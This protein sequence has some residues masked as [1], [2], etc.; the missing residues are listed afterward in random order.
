[1]EPY[2]DDDIGEAALRAVMCRLRQSA[3]LLPD[4]G[5]LMNAGSA[6]SLGTGVVTVRAESVARHVHEALRDSLLAQPPA[7]T[8]G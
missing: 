8:E 7:A 3:A 6:T 5:L 2:D 4:A 1:M